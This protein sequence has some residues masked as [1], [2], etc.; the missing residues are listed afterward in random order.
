MTPQIAERA[1]ELYERQ[2]HRRPRRSGLD[3][4]EEVR[5]DEFVK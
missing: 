5:K 3:P 1:Y 2:G 4:A